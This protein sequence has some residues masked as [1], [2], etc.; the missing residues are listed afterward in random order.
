M[1]RDTVSLIAFPSVAIA[2]AAITSSVSADLGVANVAVG[3]AALTT[4]AGVL[5]W[6]AGVATSISAALALNYF[7]TSPKHSLRIG[8]TSDIVMVVLLGVIGLTVSVTTALRTRRH[9]LRFEH[10]ARRRSID[11]LVRMLED[12]TPAVTVWHAAV[13]A[14][15][16]ALRLTEVRLEPAR[17]VADGR[18]VVARPMRD[19]PDRLDDRAEVVLPETGAILNFVDP[20]VAYRLSITPRRGVGSLTVGRSSIF[21][22]ADGIETAL[23]GASNIEGLGTAD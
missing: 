13:D 6:P 15:D 11:E 17:N 21:R 14:C 10:D 22:L 16:H 23:L 9:V 20:R 2:L 3:L 18:P 5:A 7:H 8:S 4:I 12:R 1:R 19:A